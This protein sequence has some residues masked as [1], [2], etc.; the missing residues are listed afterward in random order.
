M[1]QPFFSHRRWWVEA[2][3]FLS[4]RWW[5]EAAIF[6]SH[7][8]W[9]AVAA[10]FLSHR[11]WWDEAAI[12]LSQ[13]MVGWSSHFSLTGDGGLEQPFWHLQGKKAHDYFQSVKEKI[14]VQNWPEIMY[15]RK[16]GQAYENFHAK[17]GS[18][19]KWSGV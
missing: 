16:L 7:R 8:R 11:R 10:I 9:W 6:L 19:N 3:I 2:A 15:K 4:L 14:K 17:N 18:G 1:K 12:F 13:E 5:A